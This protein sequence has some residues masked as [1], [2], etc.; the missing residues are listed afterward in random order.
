MKKL[1]NKSLVYVFIFVPATTVGLLSSQVDT[2][3][4]LIRLLSQHEKTVNSISKS[5]Y[6]NFKTAD[7]SQ[8]T[9]IKDRRELLYS[10]VSA[11]TKNSVNDLES[12]KKWTVFLQDKLVHPE[13]PPL[14][15]NGQAI[16]DPIWILKNK[17]AHCG[18]T[19]RLIVD[20]LETLGIGGRVVQLKDHVIAEVFI[21]GEPIALDAD[22]LDGGRFYQKSDGSI[23]SA[24]EIF[25]NPSF[26][27]ILRHNVYTEY[28]IFGGAEKDEDYYWF[29]L[30]EHF[31]VEP[32]YYVK[33][34]S[35]SNLDNEYYGWNHYRTSK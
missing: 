5:E 19:S 18:Q 16:Y 6:F 35:Q 26:L 29:K 31:S 7:S 13:K 17:F 4:P 27:N 3:D 30:K 20:G 22:L 15:S 10:V 28:N 8:I 14:L 34:A 23:P 25:E 2:E 33:T 21:D 11:V 32:Y 9:S 1:D 24:Q 12:A